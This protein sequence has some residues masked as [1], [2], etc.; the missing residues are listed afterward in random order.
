M[1]NLRETSEVKRI[2]P[3]VMG[4]IAR[5]S[6]ILHRRSLAFELGVSEALA[7]RA[8]HLLESRNWVSSIS[9][10]RQSDEGN[11]VVKLTAT[12]FFM[13]DFKAIGQL[14]STQLT[15]NNRRQYQD[16]LRACH[17][18]NTAEQPRKVQTTTA[19]YLGNAVLLG[20]QVGLEE[21]GWYD[22][23]NGW[24]SLVELQTHYARTGFIG[25][26]A[27]LTAQSA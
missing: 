15:G 10:V 13:E 17:T 16:A 6:S 21:Y 27:S 19:A 2:T 25:S 18:A 11:R 14:V 23:F 8:V 20:E 7:K 12:S 3:A 5:N 4:Q 24:R 26:I 9:G 22:G 1:P